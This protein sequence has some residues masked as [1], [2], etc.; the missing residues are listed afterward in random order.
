MGNKRLFLNNYYQKRSSI[1]LSTLAL[2]LLMLFI[3]FHRWLAILVESPGLQIA[4]VILVMLFFLMKPT[5]NKVIELSFTSIDVIWFF[6]IVI[7]QI[8]IVLEGVVEYKLDFFMYTTV[9]LLLILAKTDIEKF[10]KSLLII[11]YVAIFNAV[12]VILHYLFTDNFNRIIFKISPLSVQERTLELTQLNYYPAFGFAQPALTSGYLIMGIGVTLALWHL[13]DGYKRKIDIIYMFI[14]LLGVFMVGKRSFI[15]WGVITMVFTYYNL[16][17]IKQKGIRTIKILTGTFLV[18][19]ISFFII[20]YFNSAP[21]L[22]RIVDTFNGLIAGEDI[23]SGRTTLYIAAWQLFLENPFFGIGWQQFINVTSGELLSRDLTVHN[24]YIQLLTEIGIIGF[25]FIIVA[26]IYVFH[27]TYIILK[28][29]IKD[30][31]S[32]NPLWKAGI[33]FSFYYQVF[34][35]LYCFTENPFYNIIFLLMYFYSVAIVNNFI[36]LDK[37]QNKKTT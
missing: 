37:K 4:I 16:S 31:K 14:L 9:I 7:I 21:F 29:I 15:L 32:Y 1:Y 13:R 18:F 20:T 12:A 26:I 22:N 36:I 8:N 6:A 34:F 27:N 11:K 19:I 25:L 17:T 5:K 3:M 28:K 10:E 30:E 2:S 24:V 33:I 23:T 35:L